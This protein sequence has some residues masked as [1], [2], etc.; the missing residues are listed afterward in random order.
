MAYDNSNSGV[1]FINNKRNGNDR[2]PNLK[3]GGRITIDGRE[4]ELDLAAWTKRSERA[5]KFLSL[6]IN[7]RATKSP[8]WGRQRPRARM[9]G[10]PKRKISRGNLR[11][12]WASGRI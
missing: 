5:D 4:Y 1:L 11:R 3:G 8:R 2:A 10:S 12:R 6:S 9:M 7:S